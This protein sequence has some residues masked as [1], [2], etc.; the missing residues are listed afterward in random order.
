M[1]NPNPY[2]LMRRGDRGAL[3]TLL[4]QHG[5]VLIAL[6]DALQPQAPLIDIAVAV[7]NA[8]LSALRRAEPRGHALTAVAQLLVGQARVETTVAQTSL[9]TFV[10]AVAYQHLGL[11]GE[12]EKGLVE[13]ALEEEPELR[14]LQKQVTAGL[15]SA[16]RASAEP[17]TAFEPLWADIEPLLK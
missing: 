13:R 15:A 10:F 16:L 11:G 9:P 4:H 12:A 6:R 7:W 3:K 5:S 2:S 1:C 17:C 8:S 14:D